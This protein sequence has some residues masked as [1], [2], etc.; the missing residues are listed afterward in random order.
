MLRQAITAFRRWLNVATLPLLL[1]VAG[2]T[3]MFWLGFSV[4]VRTVADDVS[5]ASLIGIVIGGIFVLVALLLA[6]LVWA[7]G[8]GTF[9]LSRL[10]S[11]TAGTLVPGVLETY[12]NTSAPP[13]A[14]YA[15]N[16]HLVRLRVPAEIT[17]L[18]VAPGADLVGLVKQ[19][20]ETAFTA[21]DGVTGGPWPVAPMG[22]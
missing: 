15:P 1:G 19:A 18:R 14:G 8:L 7:L 2:Y 13:W 4:V 20:E 17:T 3:V 11:R 16:E 5:N 9:F 12:L 22:N 6:I 21:L 10:L